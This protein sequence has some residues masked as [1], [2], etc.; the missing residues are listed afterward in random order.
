MDTKEP[1]NKREYKGMVQIGAGPDLANFNASVTP[2]NGFM[3][4]R[5]K[6]PDK[7]LRYLV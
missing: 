6:R 4:G 2:V 7:G 5:K 3:L 1:S